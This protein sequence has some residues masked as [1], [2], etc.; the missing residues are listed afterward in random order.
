MC[1]CQDQSQSEA[2]KGSWK[3]HCDLIFTKPECCDSEELGD[4]FV[5][6]VIGRRVA[7]GA[8]RP[9]RFVSARDRVHGLSGKRGGGAL[10]SID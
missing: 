1:I 2:L 4:K 7:S 9:R 6:G 8:T 10:S 5:G 3:L